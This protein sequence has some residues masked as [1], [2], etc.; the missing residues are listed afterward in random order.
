MAK[1]YK[2]M[3]MPKNWNKMTAQEQEEWLVKQYQ[4]YCEIE[5]NISRMLARVRGGQRIIMNEIERPDELML[6]E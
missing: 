1:S 5:H 6:K 4:M 3:K 2:T